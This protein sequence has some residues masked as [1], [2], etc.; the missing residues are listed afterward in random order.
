MNCPNC[1]QQNLEGSRYCRICA[2]PFPSQDKTL[3]GN[4]L[5]TPIPVQEFS[6]GVVIG[7]KYRLL[8]KL[9]E[10]GMGVV[11]KAQDLALTRNVALKF[12][13]SW[14]EPNEE[15]RRRFI[16][17]AQ[18]AS[19]LEHPNICT[20]FEIG[21]AENGQTYIAMAYYAGET[22]EK[23]ISREPLALEQA[24]DVVI[25]IAS[26]LITAHAAGI[27][28]RDIKP[29]NVIVASDGI[30]KILDFGLA[31]LRHQPLVTRTRGR[32]G[33]LYYMAPEQ[34]ESED[35]GQQA[36]LWALGV[37]YYELLT[38]RKP[39]D[40]ENEA[41]VIHSILNTSPI[42][43][44]EVRTGI[45]EEI[46]RIIYRCLQKSPEARYLSADMLLA[47][48]QK[49]KV[50]FDI[51]RYKPLI[52]KH[53]APE[54]RE[55]TERRPATILFAEI[56][57]Y[58]E[59]M[60]ILDP[61]EM[62]SVLGRIFTA[63]GSIL[64]KYGARI[65]RIAG[66]VLMAVTGVPMAVEDAPQKSIN[67]AIELREMLERFNKDEKPRVPLDVHIGIDTGT[68][69]V[70]TI[71][72]GRKRE[73]SIIG[74]AVNQ[75][76]QLR[77]LT[78]KGEIFVGPLTYKYTREDFEFEILK[79]VAVEGRKTPVAA[80]KLLSSR[81]KIYRERLRAARR[82]HSAMV[83]RDQELD[84][85]RLHVLKVIN[86]EGSI[87]NVIGEAGIGKSRLLAELTAKEEMSRVTLLKGRGLAAGKNLSFHPLLDLLKGWAQI[88][89]EDT[90]Q[91]SSRKLEEAIR[92][93][94]P[95]GAVEI[96]PFIA[97]MMGLK[98][99]DD[100]AERVRG[101]EGEALEKLILKSL[102]ELLMKASERRPVV[103]AFDDLH[104]A[105]LTTIGFLESL[106]RLA[107]THR[108]FF[109]N[110]FRPG[111][112]ETGDRIARKVRERHPARS[113]EIRLGPLDRDQ[114]DTLLENLLSIKGLPAPLRERIIHKT[115][116]NPFFIEE[117]VR[118]FIDEG[119]VVAGEGGFRVTEKVETM[120]IPETIQEI[121]MSRIDR[122]DENTRSLLKVASVIGRN[123][124]YKIL[125]NV[126]R[127]I[128]DI[129]GRLDFLKDIELI[130]DRRRL[131]E[132]EYLFK[133]AL[134]QEVTYSSI[135]LKKR[136]ELH[137]RVAASIESIFAGRLPEFYGML[138]YHYGCAEDLEK[139]ETYLVKAGEEAL[140]AAA[141]TEAIYYYQEALNLYLRKQAGAA[142]PDKIAHLEW[143]IA[144][145]FLNK[146]HMAEAVQHFDRVMELWGE[147]RPRHKLGKFLALAVNLAKVLR[148]L[149]LPVR[150]SR[151]IPSPRLNAMFEVI[152]N[153]G[154]ALVS[155]DTWRM[156]TD[157]LRFVS[158]IR[159]YD[160]ARV[161]NGVAMYAS[162]SALFFFTGLSFPVA[163]RLLAY[164][165][166]YIEPGDTKALYK[167]NFWELA[168][169]TLAGNW[170]RE[171]KYEEDIIDR[172]MREGDPYTPPGYVYYSGVIATEQ[173][174]FREA[175]SSILKL[176]D[177]AEVY[178]N[179]YARARS[180]V[181]N[182]QFLF[183]AGRYQDAIQQ[184]DE[185]VAWL[186][187]VDQKLWAL[188]VIGVKLICSV[189]LGE[190][191]RAAE[192]LRAGE[193]I[194]A[195]ENR[196]AP[197]YI[198][199]FLLGRFIQDLYVWEEALDSSPQAGVE[200]AL[201]KRAFRSG[202]QALRNA[203]KCAVFR[204]EIIRLMGICPWLAGRQKSALSL[205]TRAIE[206][207]NELRA[208][209]ELA[210]TY[211]E[212]AKRLSESRSRFPAWKGLSASE[213][214][215]QARRL[216]DELELSGTEL[217]AAEG[218]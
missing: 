134:V 78:A 181:L 125:A 203:K 139:A 65:E 190:K 102:R 18:N 213:Y 107:E 16:Q 24:T 2:S 110:I 114:C 94:H 43:P 116:G 70:G 103:L 120:V 202:R 32:V 214:R 28:H 133:H 31:K 9:G 109:L 154:T 187:Q 198:S 100:H 167:Y 177:I 57:G 46:E 151:R 79:P 19:V 208:R 53:G 72:T 86:G 160:L 58:A 36:D 168:L 217:G 25:Q 164:A 74:D 128:E 159:K 117:V 47:D 50:S 162:S 186:K 106:F 29:S 179:D 26:G 140:K 180:Y 8:E 30:V 215:Q 141:S 178:E 161:P 171:R 145:A 85:L 56:S 38:G 196:I 99:T 163:R 144:K 185:T 88:K 146:G 23:K 209:P 113:S 207:G 157:S 84:R 135:L 105:D 199:A 176:R 40:G 101:I 71:D 115:E 44:S 91:S 150:K 194:V 35:V 7:R 205:W 81:K 69:V 14:L 89:D 183:K 6:P 80:H 96:F 17:E 193:E 210:R 93:V 52:E 121:L 61:E 37:V 212:V 172:N 42:P 104:W 22:L 59:M 15:A 148:T 21:E 76:D 136:K 55:E 189:L 124:F 174:R 87:V 184:A 75:A 68:V 197:F 60:E 73:F 143:N 206:T 54:I 153:R 195:A 129:D 83:G 127:S 4:L 175:E 49:L 138:A 45:P 216:F 165:S 11:Y 123:F 130:V 27:V 158:V 211:A 170:E 5:R 201:R 155:I 122:L 77:R 97:M 12:L 137:G 39:F 218:P 3:D 112:P 48:L 126:G 41:A 173:G 33:T 1:G 67:A 20:I 152:Y 149:Y 200:A 51:E 90:P 64:E 156:I 132:L 192:A 34:I 13:P 204:I 182:S 147:R 119:A 166:R 111:H 118:S 62:S 92:D 191:A 142:D 95:E 98:L 63:C 10:G 82:V 108:L 131:E 66:G 188:C 169:D